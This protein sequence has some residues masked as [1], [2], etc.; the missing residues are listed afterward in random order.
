MY[1]PSRWRYRETGNSKHTT[2]GEIMTVPD[3]RPQLASA[4]AWVAELIE[5]VGGDQL[6]L[7]TPCPDFD[8]RDLIAHV[9]Q[10]ADRVRG[11]GEGRPAESIT[12]TPDQL[13]ADLAAGYREHAQQAQQAW[14]GDDTL[15]RLVTAP[16]GTVPGAAA[17][18]AYLNEALAH[19]WDLA[20]A[21]GQPNEIDPE[22]ATVALQLA[23]RAVPADGRDQMP[24]A[25]VVAS[26]EDATPSTK[27]VN[28][29]GRG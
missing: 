7:S 19:G 18:G 23:Q 2:S 17:I 16:W 15:G 21:T 20:T 4:Q 27:F 25:E 22:L 29:M 14:A 8:V 11:M 28:W 1:I 5:G 24:F 12:F 9:Y 13:P 3:F 10:G 6:S 26:A